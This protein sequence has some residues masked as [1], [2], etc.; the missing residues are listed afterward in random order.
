MSLLLTKKWADALDLATIRL[1][2]SK[3]YN[4]SNTFW[5]QQDRERLWLWN[6][7]ISSQLG[8]KAEEVMVEVKSLIPK[9]ISHVT[10]TE[11]Y[12]EKWWLLDQI[13]RKFTLLSERYQSTH[14]DLHIKAFID[15]RKSLHSF[16]GVVLMNNQF[17]GIFCV[18]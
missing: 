8:I 16:T 6:G 18:A 13:H 11:L 1:P 4:I 7:Y 9:T 15:I 14:S 2:R 3:K 5:L 17:C 10:I 12:A